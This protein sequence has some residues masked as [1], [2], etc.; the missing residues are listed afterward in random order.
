MAILNQY[1]YDYRRESAAR[2]AHDN[3]QIA[4]NS[5]MTEEQAELISEL[6]FLRH[7]L[8]SNID[9]IVK[10]DDSNFKQ[11]LIELNE[12]IRESDLDYMT[13]IPAYHDDYIDIDDIESLRSLNDAGA[14]EY[15]DN[16]DYDNEYHRIYSELEEL[17]RAIE[18]YLTKI[19]KKYNTNWA[20]TGAL[21]IY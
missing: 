11:K 13:F 1:Q 10:S 3:E 2:R 4:M 17:N 19:D 16:E 6:C 15:N 9:S 12:K 21:R 8:H 14:I 5:G 20:P 7:E 18:N